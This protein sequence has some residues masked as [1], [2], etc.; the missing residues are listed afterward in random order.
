MS[1]DKFL[2]EIVKAGAIESFEANE[3]GVTALKDDFRYEAEK[4]LFLR[5]GE[6]FGGFLLQLLEALDQGPDA[7]MAL[8]NAYESISDFTDLSIER[9]VKFDWKEFLVWYIAVSKALEMSSKQVKKLKKFIWER[10]LSRPHI[11]KRKSKPVS[12]RKS[13][14]DIRLLCSPDARNERARIGWEAI[15]AQVRHY[16]KKSQAGSHRFYLNEKRFTLFYRDVRGHFF[17]LIGH[18][19]KS[20]TKLKELFEIEWAGAKIPKPKSS[21]RK[22]VYNL[23][24]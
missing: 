14:P 3:P 18:D 19:L 1:N 15:K 9:L 8:T 6:D 5:K 20:I 10:L 11:P 16:P 13:K 22:L 4:F 2:L 17:G 24:A 7:V 23:F 21:S 12:R